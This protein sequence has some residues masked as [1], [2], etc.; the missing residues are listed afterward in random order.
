LILYCSLGFYEANGNMISDL[1]KKIDTI[2][3]NHLNLP[4]KIDITPTSATQE[5]NYLYNA[6]GQKLR[7]AT[8]SN[9]TPATTTG[10][11]LPTD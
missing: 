6:V 8:R 2:H 4:D 5:I 10:N 3:Y 9:Y 1:N 7:K 11:L